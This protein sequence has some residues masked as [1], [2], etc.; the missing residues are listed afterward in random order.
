MSQALNPVITEQGLQEIFNAS[1]NG[2]NATITEVVLGDGGYQVLK[3]TQGLATQT[4][5]R[6]EKQRVQIADGRRSSPQQIDLSFVAEGPEEFWV[7]E[8]GFY[9]SSGTL[10]AVWSDPTRALAW[11]SASVPLIVG[12]ELVLAA[13]PPDSVNIQT[14]EV[15]LQLVMTREMAALGAAISNLQLEQ[16]RQADQISRLESGE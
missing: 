15:P 6:Q 11:K 2:V 9:L 3:N 13:L 12:F 5:L 1:N 16:L 8:V 7:R 14:G 10:L 4:S